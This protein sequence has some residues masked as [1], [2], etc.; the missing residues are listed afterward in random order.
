[1][2]LRFAILSFFV[3]L[4]ACGSGDD[5]PVRCI[6]GEANACICDGPRVGVQ[7]CSADGV[8][9]ACDCSGTV[10]DTNNS[11]MDAGTPNNSSNTTPNN[12]GMPDAGTD[13]GTPPDM[14]T[15]TVRNLCGGTAVLANTP[16]RVCGEC[17]DG[18]TICSTPDSTECA[19][20]STKNACG[21][22]VE[23]KRAPGDPCG[24]CGTG[25]LEC[26]QAGMLE[27]VNPGQPNACGGCS[28]LPETPGFFCQNSATGKSGVWTCDSRNSVRCSA[29][30]ENACGGLMPLTETPAAPCGACGDGRYECA[31]LDSIICNGASTSLNACG[32]CGTPLV[33]QPNAPCGACGGVWQCDGDQAVVCSQ[34]I[35]PCGGCTD[36]AQAL[37][38]DCGNGEI[39]TCDGAVS[40]TCRDGSVFNTCGGTTTLANQPGDAC[41]SCGDGIF[42]CVGND[43][44]ICAESE[45]NLNACGGC[46]PL[47]AAP[48]EPCAPGSVWTCDGTDDVQCLTAPPA[49]PQINS[50][51]G[52][53]T[54]AGQPGTTCEECGRWACDALNPDLAICVGG[55]V[56]TLVDE[57]NCGMC[58]NRCLPGE[59]CELGQCV[60]D[61]VVELTMSGRH[62]AVRL[63]G[64]GVKVWGDPDVATGDGTIPSFVSD[65]RDASL[66]DDAISI[67][68]STSSGNGS[69]TCA[70]RST[71]EV[72]CWGSNARGELGVSPSTVTRSLIPAKVPGID[73]AV[74]VEANGGTICAL[75]TDRTL[76]C[77]G[78]NAR[79]ELGRGT[80]TTYEL[81]PT[82]VP[83]LGSVQDFAVA[84]RTVCALESTGTI[85]CW[86][87]NTGG[88][89]GQGDANTSDIASP[90]PIDGSY[91][92]FSSIETTQRGFIAL[93]TD[94]AYV[95]GLVPSPL[96]G[97]SSTVRTPQFVN[98]SLGT[99]RIFASRDVYYLENAQGEILMFGRDYGQTG[100]INATNSYEAGK[101]LT[102]PP[103]NVSNIV[104]L[105][106]QA[107]LLMDNGELW[108]SGSSS[109]LGDG[110]EFND[111][112]RFT[113]EY[114]PMRS[115]LPVGSELG[116]CGDGFD[117]DNDGLT[118]CQDTDCAV[119]L[120]SAEG[121]GALADNVDLKWYRYRTLSCTTTSR[122]FDRIFRW[123]APRTGEFE[124]SSGVS[125]GNLAVEVRGQCLDGAAPLV[126][127]QNDIDSSTTDPTAVRFN[128]VGGTEYYFYIEAQ[129]AGINVAMDIVEVQP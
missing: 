100:D 73:S 51:G 71:G 113:R 81:V 129:T 55:S 33:G 87:E 30:D 92:A 52:T 78:E 93:N 103:G 76:W 118:D 57:S 6:E 106:L 95:W 47:K 63:T 74:R 124:I 16:G 84:E 14:G 126:C 82:Q 117:N 13:T 86:G 77:W 27:C 107:V 70:V 41:G 10:V 89:A 22:C 35:N 127:N 88:E 21:S 28:S 68:A 58:G 72:W 80:V 36:L 120:A 109:V 115:I 69:T 64:G 31:S 101:A 79:G 23:L 38:S 8:F 44:T 54:L 4:M 83:G 39:V 91:P 108:V 50:C 37:G 61:Q 119:D 60:F 15:P 1:M 26:S 32:G 90:S 43:A 99:T 19:Y 128:A 17:N 5:G 20:A 7:I 105:N 104:G 3:S 45:I 48:G 65:A 46:S 25:S 40:T 66:I 123:T 114:H 75:R 121:V 122:W 59:A 112:S 9:G 102:L 116:N 125:T 94:G 67:S 11:S 29:P 56:G 85:Q 98:A 24:P 12:S 110:Q 2:L 34:R 53:G 62:Y 97:V 111:S 49:N 96:N 42:I 18:V